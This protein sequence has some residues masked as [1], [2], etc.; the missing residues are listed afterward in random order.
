[1]S[2]VRNTYLFFCEATEEATAPRTRRIQEAGTASFAAEKN[3]V[4]E[5]R[6]G[7]DKHFQQLFLGQNR[8]LEKKEKWETRFHRDTIW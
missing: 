4:S 1:M 7:G 8:N 5:A 3:W 6:G 2:R